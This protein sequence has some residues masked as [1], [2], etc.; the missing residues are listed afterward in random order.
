[1]FYLPRQSIRRP[2]DAADALNWVRL[3]L[4]A[5]YGIIVF[6]FFLEYLAGMVNMADLEDDIIYVGGMIMLGIF[7]TMAVI[8]SEG[9]P[10]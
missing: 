1:M 5:A 7:L 10:I 3:G 4:I 8:T 9:R 2:V 6:V